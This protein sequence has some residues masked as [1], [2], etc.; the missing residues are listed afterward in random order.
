MTRKD[1]NFCDQNLQFAAILHQKHKIYIIIFYNPKS[2]FFPKY[3]L[4]S[5]STRSWLSNDIK[6]LNL[7]DMFQKLW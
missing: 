7:F 3:F 5:Y 1:W 6:F 2:S 4:L